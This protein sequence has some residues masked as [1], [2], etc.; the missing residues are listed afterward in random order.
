MRVVIGLLGGLTA[1]AALAYEAGPVTAGGTITGMVRF[2]GK[3]PRIPMIKVLK[4]ADF[5]GD[6]VRDPVLLVDRA[7]RGVKNTVVYIENIERG[8]PFG[9]GA[10]LDSVKCL[11]EPHVQ[12]VFIDSGLTLRNQDPVLHNPHAFTASGATI[13]NVALTQRG[14]SVTKSIRGSGPIRVQ[15]DAHLHMNAWLIALDHPYVSVTDE[16]GRFSLA[17]VPPGHYR[18]IAWHEG[19]TIANRDAYEAS[20]AQTGEDP[21]RPAY[22]APYVLTQEIEVTPRGRV[23]VDFELRERS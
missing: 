3:S 17:D 18:L 4:N 21:E 7:S 2:A 5:C 10:K 13:W 12:P 14:Q 8:K 1:P 6:E 20:L 23:A 9:A 16:K 19:F 15:C 22:D 11:F